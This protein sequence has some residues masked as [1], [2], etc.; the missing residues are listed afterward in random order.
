MKI[1]QIQYILEIYKTGSISKAAQNFY[2]SRPNLSNS[3]RNLENEVG[4]DILE[5]GTDGVTFTKKGEAFVRHGMMIMKEMEQIKDLASEK[6]RLQFGIVNPNCPMVESAFI[7]LCKE[8]DTKKLFGYQISLYREYQYESMILLNQRKADLAITVSRDLSAPS[9]LREMKERGL[10]YRKIK[11]VPCNVNLS[12]DHPLAHDPEFS[13]SKL[14]EYPFVEY[15]I[16]SDRSSPF[17][18]IGEVSFINLSKIIRVDSG[19]MRSQVISR[20]N[21]YGIGIAMP[22]EWAENHKLCCISIP[23]FTLELGLIRRVNQPVSVPEQRF[24]EL[25]EEEVAFLG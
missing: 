16:K 10:E 14:A 8:V 21:A 24:L 7:R 5:R 25:F 3:I 1:E 23:G 11:D 12:K 2:M 15:A 4:F 9:L 19:H 13:F 17:N 20:T 22:P 18:R 6:E